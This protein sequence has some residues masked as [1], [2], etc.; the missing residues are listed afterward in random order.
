MLREKE[1]K[2]GREGE[3]VVYRRRGRLEKKDRR[4]SCGEAKVRGVR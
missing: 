1:R 4:K 3:G 2:E